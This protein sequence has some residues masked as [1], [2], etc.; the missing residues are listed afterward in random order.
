ME[1]EGL[2]R[3]GRIRKPV[4]TYAQEQAEDADADELAFNAPPPKRQKRNTPID[5]TDD[6]DHADPVTASVGAQ[7][8]KT[9]TKRGK[10]AKVTE[11]DDDADEPAPS[12]ASKKRK[13][14]T[15]GVKATSADTSWHAAAAERRIAARQKR[16]RSLAPGQEEQRLR[17]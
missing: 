15:A 14:G 13:K 8:S 9:I 12:Q 11:Q 6:L 16:V 7:K 4:K 3:S 5:L 1:T 17:A 10:K 2:R